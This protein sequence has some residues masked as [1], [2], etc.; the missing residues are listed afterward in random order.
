[1]RQINEHLKKCYCLTT[2]MMFW[3]KNSQIKILSNFPFPEKKKKTVKDSPVNPGIS[4][5]LYKFS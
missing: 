2:G 4:Q 1:M 3:M 5:A